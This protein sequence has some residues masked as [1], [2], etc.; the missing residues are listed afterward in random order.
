M[1]T[2]VKHK[3]QTGMNGRYLYS[4]MA[5]FTTTGATV[6][7]EVPFDVIESF[8]LTPIG[9]PAASEAPLSINEAATLDSVSGLYVMKRDAT[10]KTVTVT[11]PAGT[12]SGLKFAFMFWGR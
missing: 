8:S 12:T 3:I 2:G 4:G 11:R 1:P 5:A 10:T 7:V 9:T 6:E